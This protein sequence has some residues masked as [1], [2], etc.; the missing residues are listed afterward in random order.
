M[1][2]FEFVAS[3]VKSLAW[4]TALVVVAIV[5]RRPIRKVLSRIAT[6]VGAMTEVRAWK[7]R[8][9]FAEKTTQVNQEIADEATSIGIDSPTEPIDSTDIEVEGESPRDIIVLAWLQLEATL[10]EAAEMA[11]I[12]MGPRALPAMQLRRYLPSDIQKRLRELM[13][14]RNQ[15]TH[16]LHFSVS[17]E[18][19]IEYAKAAS[20]LG[21]IVRHP[22]T[23]FRMREADGGGDVQL[24]TP[25]K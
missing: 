16:E 11:G 22:S 18:T 10:R 25:G 23:V 4:P 19:A 3:L 14:L 1:D 21:A 2:G 17:R 7:V 5:Y 15:A 8:A 24:P 20:K 12:E 9:K 6:R 13:S